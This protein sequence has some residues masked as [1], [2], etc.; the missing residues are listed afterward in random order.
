M[1]SKATIMILL[2]ALLVLSGCVTAKGI[3]T[4]TPS[5]KA[6]TESIIVPPTTT[7]P[8]PTEQILPTSTATMDAKHQAM[9][10]TPNPDTNMLIESA[11]ASYDVSY[12]QVIDWYCSGYA[13]E[14]IFVALE[15]S[16][17]VD[18]P[19]DQL[20]AMTVNSSWDTIWQQIG[21]TK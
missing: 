16:Q 10:M 19:A 6:A 17:A 13:F 4:M 18:I 12:D 15:T 14:D 8:A 2:V 9:C 20:L 7:I 21:F 11:T 5:P 1:K 3:T